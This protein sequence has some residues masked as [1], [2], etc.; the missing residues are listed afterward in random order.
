MGPVDDLQHKPFQST[1]PPK[2]N[3]G[4]NFDEESVAAVVELDF[5]VALSN[6][7]DH[8]RSGS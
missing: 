2:D 8:F 1:H 6:H 5:I 7:V 3:F 4:K